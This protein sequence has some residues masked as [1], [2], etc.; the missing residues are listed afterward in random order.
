MLGYTQ[1]EIKELEVKD[2]HPEKALPYVTEQFKKQAKKEIRIAKD[3][4][5]K[6]KDGSVFYADVASSPIVL[7][8]KEYLMGVFRDITE[9]KTSEE[10]KINLERELNQAHKLESI[11]T[12][13]A[14]IAHEINTPIQFISDNAEFIAES[15]AEVFSF[16]D[17]SLS[18]LTPGNNIE[19]IR[20]KIAEEEENIDLN[21]LKTE[22]PKAIEQSIEGVVRVT[23][24]VKAMK[25]F[26][27]IGQ[28]EE[29]QAADINDAIETT[30]TISRNEWKYVAEIELN[31]EENLPLVRCFIGDIKQVILNLIVNAA[32]SIEDR[33]KKEEIE[34]GKITI[35]TS[36]EA[37]QVMIS[38]ADTGL[39]IPQKIQGKVFDHFFTTKGVGKGTGQG[40]SMAYATV[41][42]K[43]KGEIYFKTKEGEGTTFFIKLPVKGI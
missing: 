26:S 40:L 34:K 27:H 11:G 20:K 38:I 17:S 15:L 5:V 43:H 36:S 22:I 4:P 42:E 21:Y 9:R 19:D 14:G 41:V 2:I 25:D 12:L 8:D 23:K 18:L 13:A 7:G 1:K 28:G 29:Q 3:I 35:T 6:R 24:I 39:G 10:E 37:E 32:H 33:V 30:M 16:I 31:L